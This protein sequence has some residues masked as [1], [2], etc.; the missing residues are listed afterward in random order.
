MY[1][2]NQPRHQSYHAPSP[3]GYGGSRHRAYQQHGPPVGADPQL[4]QWFSNVDVDRSGSITV[5]EL[6]SAL[7]NGMYQSHTIYP[8]TLK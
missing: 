2:Y 1:N 7:V 8:H 4:W 3:E 6:Q 5:T